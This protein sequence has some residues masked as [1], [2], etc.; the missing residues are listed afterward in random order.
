MWIYDCYFTRLT[1]SV[2]E[3]VIFEAD[4]DDEACAKADSH[5]AASSSYRSVEV[6]GSGR[7]I[8]RLHRS[9]EDVDAQRHGAA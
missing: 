1:G 3:L 2:A 9:D 4:N 7:F 6:F 5:F 8:A